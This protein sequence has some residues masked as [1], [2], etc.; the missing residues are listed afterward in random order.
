MIPKRKETM[1]VSPLIILASCLKAL[2]RS[3]DREEEGDGSL[4]ELKRKR[5]K[6]R[7]LEVAGI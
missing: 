1:D 2:T 4:L 6:L 5:S 3:Q 7:K